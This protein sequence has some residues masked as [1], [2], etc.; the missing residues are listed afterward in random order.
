[1]GQPL[2]PVC[3][4]WLHQCLFSKISL[5]TSIYQWK[6]FHCQQKKG[7]RWKSDVLLLCSHSCYH[8]VTTI[9]KYEVIKPPR[10]GSLDENLITIEIYGQV[11]LYPMTVRQRKPGDTKFKFCFKTHICFGL[12]VHKLGQKSPCALTCW[13]RKILTVLWSKHVVGN[14][15][16]TWENMF[17]SEFTA[18]KHCNV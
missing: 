15:P 14:F 17:L 3:P 9:I 18:E 13:H 7:H 4:W 8:I 11:W 2:H 5:P 16:D 12:V 10:W 1:M 6:L